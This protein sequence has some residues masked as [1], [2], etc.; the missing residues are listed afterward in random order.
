[1]PLTLRVVSSARRASPRATGTKTENHQSSRQGGWGF[2]RCAFHRR[3]LARPAASAIEND[4]RAR[5]G[6]ALDPV[7]RLR[8]FPRAGPPGRRLPIFWAFA[9]R[10]FR[11][12]G[13]GRSLRRGPPPT[14]RTWWDYPKT[15]WLESPCRP[16]LGRAG[17]RSRPASGTNALDQRARTPLA[18]DAPADRRSRDGLPEDWFCALPREEDRRAPTRGIFERN[19]N[20]AFRRLSPQIVA[21][22]WMECWLGRPR[23]R[24]AS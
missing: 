11:L 20:L 13:V 10:A 23:R 24:S 21:N 22:L 7:P 4:S 17:W 16:P 5:P 19:G 14:R 2:G 18:L 9:G 12:R 15:D 6:A 1:M 8:G 3:A